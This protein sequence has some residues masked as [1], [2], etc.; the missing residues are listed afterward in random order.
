MKKR[1]LLPLLLLILLLS[2]VVMVRPRSR[3]PRP[4]KGVSHVYEMEIPMD[5]IQDA[6][7]FYKP[8]QSNGKKTY[9][10]EGLQFYTKIPG[11]K[12][13]I[14]WISCND[15]K[16]YSYFHKLF[17][18]SGV[19]RAFENSIVQC[20]SKIRL[21]QAFFVVRQKC[22]GLNFHTDYPEGVG[23]QAFTLATPLQP[24]GSYKKTCHLVY[25]DDDGKTRMYR[26]EL[27]KAIIFGGGFEHSTQICRASSPLGFLC[28]TFGT[29]QP[30]YWPQIRDAI[31]YQSR[32]LFNHKGCLKKRDIRT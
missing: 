2:I 26:Y 21:Y 22:T 31:Q 16:T 30:E 4:L 6:K 7:R 8:R 11:W 19:P 24:L 14:R 23:D 17:V 9:D 3:L 27:G 1:R 28:F 12:S 10:V 13:D 32:I 29:D 25:K 20:D 5:V 18:D 15:K